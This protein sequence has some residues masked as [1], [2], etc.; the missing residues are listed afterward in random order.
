MEGGDYGWPLCYWD[1]AQELRVRMPEY[2]GDGGASA[3]CEQYPEPLADFPAHFAP[4]DMVF[5]QGRS[6]PEAY[7]GGAF[8]A[9]HGS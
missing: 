4:N 6:F 5:Y 1:S 9:F 2:G 7:R 3:G 8:I